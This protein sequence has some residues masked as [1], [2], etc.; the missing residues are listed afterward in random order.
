MLCSVR[1]R[2]FLN[3]YLTTQTAAV[4]RTTSDGNESSNPEIKFDVQRQ[5]R[6]GSFA[7]DHTFDRHRALVRVRRRSVNLR[8]H[9][10]GGTRTNVVFVYKIR[11]LGGVGGENSVSAIMYVHIARVIILRVDN[12]HTHTHTHAYLHVSSDDEPFAL[13]IAEL[14]EFVSDGFH[15]GTSASVVVVTVNSVR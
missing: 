14:E 6:N 10:R 13:G 2:R 12:T 15:Y 8:V 11:S 9:S 5:Q 3:K 4:R 1:T 7:S